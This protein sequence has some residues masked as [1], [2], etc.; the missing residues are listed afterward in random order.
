MYAQVGTTA[1]AMVLRDIFI[2]TFFIIMCNYCLNCI[3]FE[4][5]SETVQT[6]DPSRMPS[7]LECDGKRKIKLI[8]NWKASSK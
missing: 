2:T 8:M 6:G 5:L 3:F 1:C 7:K 4:P